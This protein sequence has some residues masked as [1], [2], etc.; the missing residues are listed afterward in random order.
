MNIKQQVIN[1]KQSSDE[2]HEEDGE[3]AY[4]D[5]NG[6]ALGPIKVKMALATEIAYFRKMGVY[7]N[8]SLS[9][10]WEMIV[11]KIL[12]YAGYTTTKVTL[13]TKY[14]GVCWYQRNSA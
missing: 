7:V 9:K 5:V 8:A 11:K 10:C 14:T 4:D 12:E 13:R 2:L 3:C 6:K 1:A